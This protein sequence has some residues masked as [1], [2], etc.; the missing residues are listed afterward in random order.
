MAK[1]AWME[2]G[3]RRC[4]SVRLE[5]LRRRDG[6][7]RGTCRSDQAE[8]QQSLCNL[9]IHGASRVVE[10]MELA[11]ELFEGLAALDCAGSEEQ[12]PAR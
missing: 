9:G 3:R 10:P 8:G 7:P 11:T 4:S 6:G 12:L 2:C 5:R 1:K